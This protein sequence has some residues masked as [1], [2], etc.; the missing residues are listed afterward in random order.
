[1]DG[2]MDEFHWVVG[3]A[4]RL[5]LSLL[6]LALGLWLT[7]QTCT[8]LLCFYFVLIH[9]KALKQSEKGPP[10][11]GFLC[12]V[13]AGAVF[14]FQWSR[15]PVSFLWL[16]CRFIQ[17][18]LTPSSDEPNTRPLMAKP[19]RAEER[20]C[21]GCSVP[22]LW[23]NIWIVALVS[24]ILWSSWT[25]PDTRR[26]KLILRRQTQGWAQGSGL[27]HLRA[28]WR[29]QYDLYWNHVKKIYCSHESVW[30]THHCRF[31]C[32]WC[33]RDPAPGCG[34]TERFIP[35]APSLLF[36]CDQGFPLWP[37]S[38]VTSLENSFTLLPDILTAKSTWSRHGL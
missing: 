10:C 17:I 9:F 36:M 27:H 24:T 19:Q 16:V 8:A 18:L 4:Q 5:D 11:P 33:N 30:C 28:T 20:V 25:Y 13:Q 3:A 22:E 26:I 1:M 15:M 37:G 34:V 14:V 7:W 12:L 6:T 38:N 35:R 2:W 32:Q 29:S 23:S 21:V 31:K